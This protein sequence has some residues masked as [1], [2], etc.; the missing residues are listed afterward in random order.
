MST[1]AHRRQGLTTLL[2]PTA[3][4]VL[5]VVAGLFLFFVVVALTGRPPVD[6]ATALF[7]GSVGSTREVAN[8]ALRALPT[9]LVALGWI[10]A[11]QGGR[12][13][14][15]FEG[16]VAIG[17][18]LAALVALK[19]PGLP[20][21]IH[22]PL[23]V[24][25][26][27]VGGAMWASIAAVLWIKR[28]ASEVITTLMLNMVALS[29][30]GWIV[31][32]PLQETTGVFPYSDRFPPSA[33]WPRLLSEYPLGYDVLL[34]V[35]VTAVVWWGLRSSDIGLR[36]RLTGANE[37]AA[38]LAGIR[39]TAVATTGLVVSGGIAGLAGSSMVLSG[40]S[41][42]LNGDFTAN[43]GFTGIVVAL[44][45]RNRPAGVIPAAFLLAALSRGGSLVETRVGVPQALVLVMQAVVIF[46]VAAS[47]PLVNQRITKAVVTT[48]QPQEPIAPS[49]RAVR[50][51]EVGS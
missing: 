17:G 31:R 22:L 47:T 23:A 20:G 25:G 18:I 48:V 44:I 33:R 41:T 4:S 37:R 28:N 34:V 35:G 10:V 19:L 29:V 39:T 50:P 26:G 9:S 45:A 5:A 16:Q 24:I 42:S 11:F 27:F 36:L 38:R 46:L 2:L 1:I 8:T 3:A 6:A 40:T 32:G 49:E 15:G 14:L 21:P 7:D 51:A 43:V 13:S 30:L 12:I